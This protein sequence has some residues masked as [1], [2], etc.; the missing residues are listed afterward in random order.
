MNSQDVSAF[1]CI[2]AAEAL[3]LIAADPAAAVF[4]VRD[5][6]SFQTSRLPEA[7]HLDLS[8][9]PLWMRRLDKSTPVVIYCYQ[10]NASKEYAQMFADFRFTRVYS[11]DGGYEALAAVAA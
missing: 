1:R 5:P 2:S 6:A 11:V 4:D 9:F 8:R 10:G 3:A 7:A